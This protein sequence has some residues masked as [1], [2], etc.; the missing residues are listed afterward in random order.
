M[1]VISNMLFFLFI[2]CT[3][4]NA[5]IID[6]HLHSYT[7]DDYW[8]G[9]TH[10]TGITSPKTA[11]D[12]LKETIAQMNKNNVEFAVVSG[13]VESIALYT[14]ADARFI[15]GYMDDNG[16]IPVA[17]FDSLVKNG[18][19]KV[20]GEIT[21][22]YQGKTLNDSSYHP[23]LAICE[24]YGIPVAYHTG[25]GPSM[26]PFRSCCPKFRIALGDP[27]LIEDVLVRYPAL[28]LYLMHGGELFYENAVRMMSMYLN[29]YIDVGVLLWVNPLIQDYAVRLLKLA[30]KANLLDRVMFGTDQMTWPDAI[31][32]SV[33]YL[34]SLDF[35]TTAEKEKILYKNANN[36]WG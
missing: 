12:H 29:L 6:V 25:G 11:A 19:I 18:K 10:R 27:L 1:N 15:P 16:L 26:T 21:G 13:T 2:T 30:K 14:K 17:E 5:Q 31:S 24:K 33:N 28:K 20:F 32:H 35:L 22:V 3:V 4:A 7:D 36:F 8:G 34:K 9:K 23:Y